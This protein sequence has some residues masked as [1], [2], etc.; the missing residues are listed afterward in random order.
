MRVSRGVG[1]VVSIAAP[2]VGWAF[3]IASWPLEG[4]T[5]ELCNLAALVAF[6]FCIGWCLAGMRRG[7]DGE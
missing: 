6:V 4:K 1:F 5:G 2:L 3:L 7:G